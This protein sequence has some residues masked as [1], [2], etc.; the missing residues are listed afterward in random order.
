MNKPVT[1]LA[2]VTVETPSNDLTMRSNDGDSSLSLPAIKS[3]STNVDAVNVIRWLE[4][5]LPVYERSRGTL[6]RQ[7]VMIGYALI[8][9]RDF[10]PRG[11]LA[12]IKKMQVFSRSKATL[13]RCM[14]AAQLY[15]ENRGLLTEKGTIQEPMETASLF[16]P[17]FDFNDP[18]AHPLSLDIA[19]YVGDANIADLLE[20]DILDDDENQPPNGHQKDA[21]A[22]RTKETPQGIRR[23]SFKRAFKAFSKSFGAHEWTCLYERAAP[24]ALAKGLDLGRLDLEDFLTKALEAVTAHNKEAASKERTKKGGKGL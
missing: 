2:V 17:E 11:S 7:A 8:C 3:L 19:T 14:K 24:E 16:Q 15:A 23:E 18:S 9:I 1:K 12:L 6:A 21:A 10:C 5:A 4:S 22:K 13:E 20:K